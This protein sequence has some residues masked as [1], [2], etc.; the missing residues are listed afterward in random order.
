MVKYL[1]KVPAVQSSQVLMKGMVFI[2]V[3]ND[4]IRLMTKLALYEEKKG[5][6]DIRLSKYFKGDY[7]R[8]EVIKSIIFATIGYLL[9]LGFII[10][11]RSEEIIKD[12]L[13]LNYKSIG[14]TA[15][16]YY[17]ILLIVYGAGTALLYTYKFNRSRKKLGRYYKLL[18]RLNSLYNE[19]TPEV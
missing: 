19:D 2:M 15:L 13:V 11:Y 7:V 1:E 10:F 6:E 3:N 14:T 17:I 5:K 12:A 8:Y 16:A 18:K 9:I 4:K